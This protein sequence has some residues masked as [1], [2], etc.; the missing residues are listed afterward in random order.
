MC[1]YICNVDSSDPPYTRGEHVSA[2]KG[3]KRKAAD[4]GFSLYSPHRHSQSC[5]Q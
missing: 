3:R 1:A 5:E 4:E 2:T